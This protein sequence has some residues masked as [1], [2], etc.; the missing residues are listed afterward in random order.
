MERI[1]RRGLLYDFYGELLTAHQREV[2]EGL[3]LNDMSLSEI[4]ELV[5][6]SSLQDFSRV[7]KKIDGLAP[8]SYRRN[9]T[10]L[11]ESLP[12]S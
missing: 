3:V 11:S 12:R 10:T 6:F 7:F 5:G 8:S 4:A 9:K 2:Y 1:V